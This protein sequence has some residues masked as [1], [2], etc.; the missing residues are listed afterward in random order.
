[1]EINYEFKD[2]PIKSVM[3][4]TLD[5]K[6]CLLI[7][8]ENNTLKFWINGTDATFNKNDLGQLIEVLNK[9]YNQM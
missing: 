6:N 7:N 5:N 9:F 1:M 2:S 8:K 3:F 4:T